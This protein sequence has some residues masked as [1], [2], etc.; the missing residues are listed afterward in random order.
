MT[1]SE[2]CYEDLCTAV[3]V[4]SAVTRTSAQLTA[5]DIWLQQDSNVTRR[6]VSFLSVCLSLWPMTLYQK[7]YVMCPQ[8]LQILTGSR[9]QWCGLRPS[10]LGEDRSETKN[11]SWSWSCMFDVV[12]W[13]TV[14][15][16]SSSKWSWRTQQHFN[17]YL[18]FL[19]SLLGSSLL[20]ISTVAFTYL[21]V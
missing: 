11:G 16:R 14:L 9:R 8:L 21:K 2:Q 15:S 4:Y 6:Q 13:S 3:H 12:L 1:A 20:W 17:Y 7:R 19:F 18:R 5:D 10:F